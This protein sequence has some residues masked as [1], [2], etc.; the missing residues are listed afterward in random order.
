[1]KTTRWHQ[2]AKPTSSI[3]PICRFVN[4]HVFGLKNG[5]YGCMFGLEGIDEEGLTDDMVAENIKAVEG[6]FKNLPEHGRIYQY[7]RVRK[8]FELPCQAAYRNARVSE[9][10]SERNRF[11]ERTADFRRG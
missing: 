5:G 10:I 2:H 6:A 7:V 4:E 9:A 11:L 1:M 8:G 3:V